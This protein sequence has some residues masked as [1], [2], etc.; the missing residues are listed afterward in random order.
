MQTTKTS[1]GSSLRFYRLGAQNSQE[2]LLLHV[3]KHGRP[4]VDK[5]PNRCGG[6]N[7]HL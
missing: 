7:A 2:M 5:L 6:S 3:T 1:E 4:H